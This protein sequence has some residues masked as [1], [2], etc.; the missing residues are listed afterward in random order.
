MGSL[1]AWQPGLSLAS[2]MVFLLSLFG[3]GT[4]PAAV[5]PAAAGSPASWTSGVGHSSLQLAPFQGTNAGFTSLAPETTGILFTNQMGRRRYLTNEIYLNG[6]GVAAGDVDGDGLCDLY[7]ANID[8]SNALYRNL[9]GWKFQDITAESGT[10]CAGVDATGVSLADLDGD[11]DL[12]LVVNSV[13]QG[14]FIYLN[15]GKAH[16]HLSAT[17]NPGRAGMSLALGDIDGDGDLDLYV[18]NYRTH[19]VRDEPGTR[20]QMGR[21]G[22]QV[23]VQKV[24]G[25]PVTDPELEGRFRVGAEGNVIEQGEPDVLF[26]N[27]G[28][29]GFKPVSWTDGTFLDADGKPLQHPPYD[30]GLSVAFRD[31]NGDGAPDLYVCND[32]ESPDR[33]WINDG[34]GRFRPLAAASLRCTSMFS[35]GVDFADLDRD[36]LDEL[37]VADM[38]SRTHVHRHARAPDLSPTYLSPD[39]ETRRVQ[40]S[41][42]TLFLNRGGMNFSE[43]AMLAGVN[44]SDWSWCPIFLDVDLDGYEDLL[45]TTGH[46]M[47]MMN[48]D[49][50]ME[51]ERRKAQKEMSPQEL[52]EL[53]TLFQRMPSPN[54]AFRNRGDMTFEDAG[55]AWGFDLARVSHGMALADLDNDGDMDVVINNMNDAATILRNDAQAPRLGVR[56]K[57]AGGNTRGIGARI[58]VVG[59][60]VAQSQEVIAGGRYLSSDDSQRTF[61]ATLSGSKSLTVEVRWRSGRMTTL[62]NIEPNRLLLVEEDPASRPV[63]PVP[64]VPASRP[65]FEEASQLLGHRHHDDPFNDL[66]RQPMLP[67][68]LS[69]LGPGVAWTDIDGDGWEDL[70]VGSGKGGN[71]AL[72]RNDAGKGFT[73]VTNASL[74][75]RVPRDQSGIVAIG[76][77]VFIGASNFEDG[78]TN[79]GCLRVYDLQRGVS[80]DT[81]MGVPFSTGP[82]ALGDIDLD[83][84]LDMF[85]G[86]RCLAGR[87]P[88]AAMSYLMRNDG[89]KLVLVHRFEGLGMVSGALFT[90]LDGDGQLEL[91]VACEWGGIRVFRRLGENPEEITARVGLEGQTGLW[92]SIAAGDFDGDG[93]MDLVAGNWG[94]NN[95]LHAHTASGNRLFYGEILEDGAMATLP[96][97]YEPALSKVVPYPTLMVLG[98]SMPFVRERIQ[99]FQQYGEAA[100]SEILGDRFAAM[101][102]LQ[103]STLAS[104]VFLNRGG[105]FKAVPLPWQAQV[106]P[107]FGLSVSD[108]DGDGA[109]D[110]FLAQNFFGTVGTDPMQTAGQGLLLLGD[111]RGGFRPQGAAVSGIELSGEQRGSAV[112]DFNGDG[113]ADLVVGQNREATR[114]YRNTGAKPGLRVRLAGPPGNPG[115]I[116]A[117]IRLR[118]GGRG[119]MGYGRELHAG[120][121]YW[122]MDAATQVMTF[123]GEVNQVIVRW[124]GGTSTTTVVDPGV[125]ELVISPDGKGAGQ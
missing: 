3:G 11:G 80:G 23:V 82:L 37:F 10:A 48:M 74:A 20:F 58:K 12:D 21:E 45:I 85:I 114:L 70:V 1:I 78:Q 29:G 15:D 27:D 44:A 39:P 4:A 101:R 124:P 17:L 95:E 72:F 8:G 106:A 105:V 7:F 9:G 56:L 81:V 84:D 121:G 63:P 119:L 24:N 54:V 97:Y 34:H 89:G 38:Q 76:P 64:P 77:T 51:A 68:R 46:E 86:G 112:A 125:R 107:V 83:G 13:G 53:R 57:G 116:G 40:Y 49:A 71:V 65:L 55:P 18:T 117:Q 123:P 52:L 102:E 104:T 2:L 103:V 60:P 88:Q 75:R 28:K 110:L 33:I 19:T 59:G 32:F 92:N 109:E 99:S 73:A 69:Q 31:L 96:A 113:R 90:D 47:E 22:D 66:Q 91:V 67:R 87:Y 16:F 94:F 93:R 79:G 50:I 35:M 14:T 36:G 62:T 6:S 43:I 25:R 108:F 115:A 5:S 111:G 30:W 61:A 26:L 42:N 41:M 122:S 118:G 100:V 98:K 120:S